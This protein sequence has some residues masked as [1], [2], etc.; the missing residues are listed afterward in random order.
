VTPIDWGV[1]ALGAVAIA[2][3]NWYFLLGARR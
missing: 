1:V 2:L 3:V